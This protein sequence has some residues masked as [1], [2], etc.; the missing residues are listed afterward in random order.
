[1]FSVHTKLLRTIRELPH[2][3]FYNHEDKIIKK[4]VL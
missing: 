4:V 3:R 2:T 1:M